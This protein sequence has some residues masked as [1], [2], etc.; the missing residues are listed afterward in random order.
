MPDVKPRDRYY[1]VME[2]D[3]SWIVVDRLTKLAANLHGNPLVRLSN[4][5]AVLL[6]LAMNKGLTGMSA[7]T[8]H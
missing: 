6:S 3:G 7:W 8:L 2:Q 5:D 4:A 1:A